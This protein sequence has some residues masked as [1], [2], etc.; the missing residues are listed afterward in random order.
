MPHKP[1]NILY[2]SSFGTLER[3]GQNSLFELVRRLDRR[4][5]M[6]IVLVPEEAEFVEKLAKEGILTIIQNF[7]P[8]VKSNPLTVISQLI[9]FVKIISRERISLVHSDNVR[10]TFYAGIVCKLKRIPLIWHIRINE[11][12]FLIDQFLSALVNMIVTVAIEGR[13]RF[14]YRN[15]KEMVTIHNAVDLEKFSPDIEP[16]VINLGDMSFNR[17]ILIG[18]IGEVDPRKEQKNVIQS[19]KIVCEE[20]NNVKLLFIGSKDNQKYYEYLVKL[21]NDLNLNRKVYFLGHREDIPQIMSLL[22]I[23]VLPSSLEGLPRI[24]IEAMS[25]GKP[26]VA[27]DIAGNRELVIDGVTGYLFPLHDVKALSSHLKDLINNKEKRIM[28]GQNGKARA[29]EMFDIK[30]QIPIIE[31]LYKILLRQ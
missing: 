19:F 7:P 16:A 21:V 2:L 5:F 15:E 31:E 24:I 13:K 11:G 6:P 12:N 1:Y 9:K 30:K 23:I 22:D 18:E 20:N 10:N 14:P 28:I 8:I 4:K 17:D 27:S 29:K 26:V 3:G 25:S